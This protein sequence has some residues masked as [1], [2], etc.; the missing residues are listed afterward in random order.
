MILRSI[1]RRIVAGLTSL[2]VVFQALLLTV[3]FSLLAAPKSEAADFVLGIVCAEHGPHSLPVD[4]PP[5]E[6]PSTCSLCLLCW[7]FGAGTLALLPQETIVAIVA[8]TGTFDL[9]VDPDRPVVGFSPHPP[10]RGPPA[11]A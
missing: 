1:V 6:K 8:P 2:G 11:S 5:P 10:S 4:D 3:H 9:V 7:K